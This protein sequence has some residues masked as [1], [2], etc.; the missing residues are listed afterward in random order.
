MKIAWLSIGILS[1]VLG[2][3]GIALPILP[4]VPFLLLSAFA[5][6]RSSP[7][8]HTWLLNHSTFGPPIHDWQERGAISRRTKLWAT[9]SVVIVLG[10]S[11]AAAVEPAVLLIQVVILIGVLLFIWS[12][13]DS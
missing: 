2:F 6:S 12:R 5:F 13:P 10:I 3:I 8:L 1:L 9:L 7:R 11:V 4:T